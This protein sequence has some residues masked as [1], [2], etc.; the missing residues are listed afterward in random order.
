MRWVHATCKHLGRCLRSSGRFSTPSRPRDACSGRRA[1]AAVQAHGTH[2]LWRKREADHPRGSG[3]RC[4]R[5]IS[6]VRV[7]QA[8]GGVPGA[9]QTAPIG[10]QRAPDARRAISSRPWSPPGR[11]GTPRL[12]GLSPM[13]AAGFEPATSR[14]K[15][16]QPAA[17]YCQLLPF[18]PRLTDSAPKD[19]HLP[20]SASNRC[21][22]AASSDTRRLLPRPGGIEGLMHSRL[23]LGARPLLGWRLSLRS[24]QGS[25]SARA[26]PASAADRTSG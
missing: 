26:A 4:R 11:A 15:S 12:A 24:A 17:V 18:V 3:F 20:R 21:F 7:K 16:A 5:P 25:G 8:Q 6:P 22:K 23:L 19:C 2:P 13:G 9:S 10:W 1:G 14:V